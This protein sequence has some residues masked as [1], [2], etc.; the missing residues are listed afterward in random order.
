[1]FGKFIPNTFSVLLIVLTVTVFMG[2]DNCLAQAPVTFSFNEQTLYDIYIGGE[3]A[4]V[5]R[6]VNI[7]RQAEING[8]VFIVIKPSGFALTEHQGYISFDAIQAVLPA[9]SYRVD[10]MKG[11]NFIHR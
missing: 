9:I 7:L 6:G 1:M 3:N 2:K 5:I 4:A 10:V 11:F 8:K